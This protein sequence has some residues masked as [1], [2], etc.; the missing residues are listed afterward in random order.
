MSKRAII[1]GGSIGG[2]FA[3]SALQKRGWDV[4]VY[5]RS[6]EAM[7][8][9]GAGIVTHRALI[10][11]LIAVGANTRGLGVEVGERIAVDR[12]GRRI[13]SLEHPQV[14]TSWDHIYHV[15][16]KLIPD[17]RYHVGR[18]VMG[19]RQNKSTAAVILDDGTAATA[20]VVIGA[21]GF[22]STIRAQMLPQVRP[23][24]SGYV[25]WRTQA[26]EQDLTSDPLRDIFGA[27][28]FYAPSGS[29][30]LGY[31]IAGPG[32]DL[33]PGHRRYDLVWYTPA[34]PQRLAQMLTDA[35]GTQHALSIPATAISEATLTQMRREAAATLPQ[36][37]VQVFATGQ[38]PFFTP[39]YDHHSPIMATG[40]VA[41]LGD[42]A[43][44]ARPHV[45]MGVT[46]AANDALDLARALDMP[47]V[48]DGLRSYSE[49]RTQAALAA[50]HRGRMMGGW[51][52]SDE[53]A[54]GDTE[55]NPRLAQIMELTAAAVD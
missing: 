54:N 51:I 37:F 41:L 20:D 14:V 18:D 31:P 17:E 33:R 30:I 10:D 19:Y 5:E 48:E 49:D 39:I 15:L 32:N 27:F 7:S 52:F 3:A 36:R 29:Q 46:K 22:Q 53:A 6:P 38:R 12:A 11:A 40:R 43:C 55:I 24:Y 47:K 13:A 25:V 35:H 16:R 9:R 44:V 8:G 23:E 42:A 2:L 4:H 21:D 34:D 1:C 50:H 45:G 26:D 28:T